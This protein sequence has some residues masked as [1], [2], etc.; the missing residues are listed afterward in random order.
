[1]ASKE[2]IMPTNNNTPQL[3]SSAKEMCLDIAVKLMLAQ[4][5]GPDTGDG[6]AYVLGKLYEKVKEIVADVRSGKN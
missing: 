6:A 5:Y 4:R 2:A 3:D 1:M